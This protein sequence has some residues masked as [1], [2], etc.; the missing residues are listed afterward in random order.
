[1][2][3]PTPLQQVKTRFG[4]KLELAEKMM[5]VLD[6][7]EDESD[8]EFALRVRTMSNKKL[9]RLHDLHEKVDSEFGGKTGLID[10]IMALRHPTGKPDL[11]YRAKLERYNITRLFDQ[12][13]TLKRRAKKA[14]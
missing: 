6:R 1:M 11:Q 14:A 8:D 7:F 2:T 12:H 10:A 3:K 5:K 4:S 9:L 13:T